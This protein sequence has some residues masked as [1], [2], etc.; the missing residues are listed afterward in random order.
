MLA[1][2]RVLIGK[3]YVTTDTIAAAAEGMRPE[4]VGFPIADSR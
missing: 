3:I 4:E 1:L 2:C